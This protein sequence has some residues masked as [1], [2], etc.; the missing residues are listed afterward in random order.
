MILQ[1]LFEALMLFEAKAEF[2][3]QK[4]GIQLQQAYQ[5]D[6]GQ[7][8]DPLDIVNQL[9]QADPTG[10]EAYLQWI[11]NRYVRGEFNIDE[12][13]DIR[14]TL[15]EFTRVR[16]QLENKDLNSYKTIDQVRAA[17]E[18]FAETRVVSGK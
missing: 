2:I 9:L 15:A 18:P 7:Q 14:A 6:A 12:L 16:T 8:A 1:E 4:Q 17:I 13:Q 3:A 10:R 5:R 11:V